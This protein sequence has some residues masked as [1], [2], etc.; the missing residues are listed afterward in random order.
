MESMAESLQNLGQNAQNQSAINFHNL[1]MLA[2]LAGYTDE[3]FRN[4]VKKFGVDITVSEMISAYALAYNPAKTLQMA[5]K[6]PVES[7]FSVQIAG[8]NATIIQKA[9]EILNA[10]NGIDIIDLNCGCPA[11]KVSSHG[12]GSGLLKDLNL[13]ANLINTIKTHSNK[14]YTSAKLRLGFDKKI[15]LEIANMLNDCAADFAVIHARTKTD[16]YKKERIDYDAIALIKAKTRLPIIAN[17]EID[18]FTKAKEVLRH[19]GANGVMIGRFALIEPWIFYQ[20]KHDT[21]RLP[22]ALKR[23][24]VLEHFD[25]MLKNYGERGCVIF[26]KNLHLYAKSHTGASEFRQKVNAE[27]SPKAMREMI[28]EFFGDEKIG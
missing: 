17:G 24:I 1:L 27:S 25:N 20:L 22:A 15:P 6:S 21:L 12:S 18:S 4:V 26:R 7:P 13:T 9:V 19:T 23:D 16:A 3:A 11:P 2:P 5:H 14:P 10:Q 8:N 28:G